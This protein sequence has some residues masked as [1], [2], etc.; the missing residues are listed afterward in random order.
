VRAMGAAGAFNIETSRFY[1][2]ALP[3]HV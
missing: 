3:P 2:E 1:R